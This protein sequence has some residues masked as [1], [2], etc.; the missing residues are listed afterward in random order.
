MKEYLPCLVFGCNLLNIEVEHIKYLIISP[1]YRL[2]ICE[3]MERE[4]L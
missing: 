1:P 2:M 3:K 4:T